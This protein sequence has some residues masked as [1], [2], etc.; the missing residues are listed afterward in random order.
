MQHLIL[1]KILKKRLSTP[2]AEV[3][4]RFSNINSDLIEL[5]KTD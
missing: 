3:R 2:S 1:I 4:S 5:E